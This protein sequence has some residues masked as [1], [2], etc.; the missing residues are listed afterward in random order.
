MSET[1]YEDFHVVVRPIA[2]KP[3]GDGQACRMNS[4]V[5]HVFVGPDSLH[6]AKGKERNV[7]VW[8]QDRKGND[9]QAFPVLKDAATDTMD[10][11]EIK[12]RAELTTN[13]Q[14]QPVTYLT[15]NTARKWNGELP[16]DQP[17][18]TAGTG[19]SG[20]GYGQS[21]ED[22]KRIVACWALKQAAI[23]VSHAVGAREQGD[24]HLTK[25]DREDVWE[26]ATWFTAG[27]YRLGA[28]IEARE[29]EWTT[30]SEAPQTPQDR[31]DD[32]TDGSPADSGGGTSWA[33]QAGVGPVQDEGGF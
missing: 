5:L 25:E 7:K 9:V 3:G 13:N 17:G 27:A 8:R 4:E 22:R 20:G 2:W 21:P 30:P 31:P 24:P 14:N 32:P 19:S 16:A 23:T 10:V 12:G 29:A 15:A 1:T 33:E 11:L 18:T 28:M 26:W 6:R